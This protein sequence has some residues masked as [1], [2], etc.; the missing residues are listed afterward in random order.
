MASKKELAELADALGI[1][2]HDPE[3]DAPDDQ[4][5]SVGELEGDDLPPEHEVD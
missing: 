2:D 3:G 5:V 1:V 4:K